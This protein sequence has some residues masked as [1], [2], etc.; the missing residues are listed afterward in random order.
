MKAVVFELEIELEFRAGDM[1]SVCSRNE[2][3]PTD[4]RRERNNA[5]VNSASLSTDHH[6]C[7]Y[8]V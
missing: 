7:K 1:Y 5:I 2:F 4:L 6:L 8:T 3:S